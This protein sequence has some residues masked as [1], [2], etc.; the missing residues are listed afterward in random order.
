MRWGHE[1]KNENVTEV[2]N[3]NVTEGEK[4]NVAEGKKEEYDGSWQSKM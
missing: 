3:E 4:K 1:G 2:E